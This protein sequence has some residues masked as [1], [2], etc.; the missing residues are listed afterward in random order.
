[1]GSDNM[2]ELSE[3]LPI[4]QRA[5]YWAEDYV[6]EEWNEGNEWFDNDLCGMCAIASAKLWLELKAVG[7]EPMIVWSPVEHFFVLLDGHVIDITATQYN[8]SEIVILPLE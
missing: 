1:M 8:E 6:Q 4:T 3:L 2:P 7:Y 5:R